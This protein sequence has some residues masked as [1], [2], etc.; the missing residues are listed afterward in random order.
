MSTLQITE[1]AR[2][3]ES[4]TTQMQTKMFAIPYAKCYP[5]RRYLQYANESE[6][7]KRVVEEVQR[8][9]ERMRKIAEH[10]MQREWKVFSDLYI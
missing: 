3:F 2:L 5:A 4:V 7:N 1:N 8:E 10:E 6:P 9:I